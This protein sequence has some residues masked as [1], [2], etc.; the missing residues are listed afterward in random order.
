MGHARDYERL[1]RW[2]A[3]AG[4]VP[5]LRPRESTQALPSPTTAF[6]ERSSEKSVQHDFFLLIFSGLCP[7]THS[8]FA[9][10]EAKLL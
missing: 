7:E 3:F 5:R 8:L 4:S 10:R 1:V 9:K 2:L 6:Q